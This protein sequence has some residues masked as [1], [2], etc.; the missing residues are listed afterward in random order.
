[1]QEIH[2]EEKRMNEK[3]VQICKHKRVCRTFEVVISKPDVIRFR[4][5]VEVCHE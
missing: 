1:M 4:Q 5:V 2:V 3:N